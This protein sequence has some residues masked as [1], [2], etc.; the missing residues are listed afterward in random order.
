[1]AKKITAIVF[2]LMYSFIMIHDFLPHHH[3]NGQEFVQYQYDDQ[4]DHE[5]ENK[6]ADNCTETDKCNFP[7]H[8]HNAQEAGIY[9]ASV[10]EEFTFSEISLQIIFSICTDLQLKTEEMEPVPYNAPPVYK[11]PLLTSFSLRGPPLS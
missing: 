5:H 2:L 10:K 11:E 4:C 6:P 8:Q 1:M 9:L 3:H 7:F